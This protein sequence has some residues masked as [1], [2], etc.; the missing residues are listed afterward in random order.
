MTMRMIHASKVSPIIE[1]AGLAFDSAGRMYLTSVFG[2]QVAR[3]VAPGGPLVQLAQVTNAPV[4][5]DGN[6][7]M[8]GNTLYTT[9]Y[10]TGP[11]TPGTPD[12]LVAIS[13]A[14]GAVT[15]LISGAAAPHLGNAHLWG[16]H[17][18]IFFSL[19]PTEHPL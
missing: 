2:G 9:T 4:E 5:L 19:A 7:V 16:A 10:S 1:P 12:S 18:M 3:E 14:T 17:N 11:A 8:L 6:L 15:P 13:T